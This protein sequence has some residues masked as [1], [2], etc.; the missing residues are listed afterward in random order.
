M[1]LFSSLHSANILLSPTYSA[2]MSYFGPLASPLTSAF[3]FLYRFPCFLPQPHFIITPSRFRWR[4][5]MDSFFTS[6]EMYIDSLA[7]LRAAAEWEWSTN[8]ISFDFIFYS[9]TLS[10]QD[11]TCLTPGWQMLGWCS[12]PCRVVCPR[13]PCER[14][15]VMRHRAGFRDRVFITS[16]ADYG[17]ICYGLNF[18]NVSQSKGA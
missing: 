14:W 15:D 6:E 4:E 16:P 10:H 7:P 8:L 17:R 2:V 9:N 12:L 13:L 11:P 3:I 1:L 18:R 5:L